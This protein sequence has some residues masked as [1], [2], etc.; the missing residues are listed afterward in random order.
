[1]SSWEKRAKAQI[2]SQVYLPTGQGLRGLPSLP[3]KL[4]PA[5]PPELPGPKGT[6]GEKGDPGKCPGKI[7][8][9][10]SKLKALRVLEPRL[11]G[12]KCPFLDALW[13]EG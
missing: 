10:K 11:S 7:L 6:V 5:G 4:G 1:M 13:K 3:G 12:G 9:E 2:T 8:L